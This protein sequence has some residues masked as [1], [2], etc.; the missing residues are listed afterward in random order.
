LSSIHPGWTSVAAIIAPGATNVPYQPDPGDPSSAVVL[1][2]VWDFAPLQKSALDSRTFI[3]IRND[4]AG[5]S[6]LES[7]STRDLGAAPADGTWQEWL[8]IDRFTAAGAYHTR[9]VFLLNDNDT[10]ANPSIDVPYV[11]QDEL[12]TVD[13]TQICFQGSAGG[14]SRLLKFFKFSGADPSS[15]V[16][17]MGDTWSSGAWTS[18]S[19]GAG[20]RLTLASVCGDQCY[21]GCST[22]QPRARGM[23][24]LGAGF[25]DTVVEDGYVHVAAGNYIPALLMRQDT[26]LQA[27]RNLLG[28]CNVGTVRNRSFDYFW[29]QEHYGYLALVSSPTDSTGTL[30]PDDWSSVGNQ[31]DGVDVAWGPFPPY[32]VDARACLAGTRVGWTLPADGSNPGSAPGVGDWGYVVSWGAD[33]DPETLADWT[34]NPNHT[35]LPGEAGYLAAPPGLEPT[36]TVIGGWP[37]SSVNVTV[38]TA[39]RYTDPTIGDVRPYRSAALYKVVEDPARLD[40]V[41][42]VVGD[43]VNPFVT[44]SGDDLHLTWPAVPG[45][46]SYALRVWDLG[47]RLEIPCPSGLD[48]APAAPQATHIGGAIAAANLGYRVF[49]VDPCGGASAN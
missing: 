2:E 12:N 47:T 36:S 1:P 3:S 31:T 20:L 38:V 44:R 45:A 11:A 29:V 48:C 37:G 49:A 18:C 40:P 46:V 5:A 7:C 14:T 8:K 32:Q 19:D 10:G 23:L 24:A 4:L 28:T 9:D 30:P 22:L 6:C 21:P 27:G 16:M 25:A 34:S 41:S 26:D 43:G 39:L 42:F 13:H 33:N 17:K 35:P 15:A